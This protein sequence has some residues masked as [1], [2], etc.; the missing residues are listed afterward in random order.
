MAFA[1]ETV[2]DIH[3]D[4]ECGWAVRKQTAAD[5]ADRVQHLA[6][7]LGAID[8]AYGRIRPS[9]GMRKFRLGDRGPILDMAR[10]EL[11]DLIERRGRFDPPR[12][13]APVSPTGYSVL[14]RNDLMGLDPSY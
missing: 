2:S 13:P 10:A 11:A 8:P 14:Y 6:R 1:D 4:F 3:R 5:V 9:P 7:R 12:Y